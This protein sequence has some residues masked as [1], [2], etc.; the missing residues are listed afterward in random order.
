MNWGDGRPFD[1]PRRSAHS[2]RPG[3]RGAVA[4]ARHG[5]A[6][7]AAHPALADEFARAACGRPARD[8][9]AVLRAALAKVDRQARRRGHAQELAGVL[10][11]M[12]PATPELLGGSADLTASNLTE[13][14]GCARAPATTAAM[15]CASSAW[16]RS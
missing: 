5:G 15:A 14:P 4:G 8:F 12:A 11:W 6:I 9:D 3:A 1:V 2:R 16:R 13:G 7:G 10:A